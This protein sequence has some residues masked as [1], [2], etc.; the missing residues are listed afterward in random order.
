MIT[1][2][3]FKN[4]YLG[5][6]VEYHSYGA[7]AYNQ[8]VDLINAYIAEVLDGNTKDYTEII[9]THAKDFDTKYDPEDFEWIANTPEGAAQKGDI[10]VWNEKVGSGYGHVAICLWGDI[11][12]IKTL[13]QN[14]SQKERVTLETHTYANVSG[15]LRPKGGESMDMM[16]IEKKVFE[17]LISE[18]DKL[19]KE[20]VPTKDATI[21]S[22]NETI[23]EKNRRIATLTD[24]AETAKNR[25]EETK[26]RNTELEE[27]AKQLPGMKVELEQAI[28]DRKQHFEKL[29]ACEKNAGKNNY[30]KTTIGELL[31]ELVKKVLRIS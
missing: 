27:I 9:G 15:W 7:G 12:G 22:L 10:I 31:G 17:N 30:G 21:K 26:H 14:W 16:Q 24:E 3:E 6:Q 28:E 25:L 20:I 4:K 23:D 5:K 8:C 29:V 13:D 18:L 2:D 19:K 11:Q 1:L